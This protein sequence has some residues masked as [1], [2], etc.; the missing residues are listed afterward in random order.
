MSAPQLGGGFGGAVGAAT[1][2]AWLAAL[3]ALAAFAV[4]LAASHDG[5]LPEHFGADWSVDLDLNRDRPDDPFKP[6]GATPGHGLEWSRL[7][8]HVEATLGDRAP[9]GL[10]PTSRA[11]F[12]RAAVDGWH[13]DG[14]PGFVYIRW[15]RSVLGTYLDA[16]LMASLLN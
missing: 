14:A 6:F 4:E 10:L 9:A 2:V 16:E 8:L 1:V 3:A 13:T 5:R 15:L 7:L 12:D 11:L